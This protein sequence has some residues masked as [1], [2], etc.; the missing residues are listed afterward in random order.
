MN[1]W[2]KDMYDNWLRKL[3]QKAVEAKNI[4]G[5]FMMDLAPEAQK[6]IDKAGLKTKPEQELRT[7]VVEHFGKEYFIAFIDAFDGNLYAGF[8]LSYN[9]SHRELY[10]ALQIIKVNGLD[11]AKLVNK[12]D[13]EVLYNINRAE[14]IV[15]RTGG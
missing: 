4:A 12:G 8:F 5:L 10:Q 11:I 14:I 1:S 15:R 13:Y 2:R 9:R 3:L 6:H 7:L